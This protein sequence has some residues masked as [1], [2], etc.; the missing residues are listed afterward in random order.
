MNAGGNLLPASLVREGR[1]NRIVATQHGVNSYIY[2][3]SL[4]S[5]GAVTTS[6]EWLYL[7]TY[8][9]SFGSSVKAPTANVVAQFVADYVSEHGGNVSDADIAAAV[10][11]YFEE[12]PMVTEETDPTVP[13]WAKAATKPSYTAAE[14]GALPSTYTPPNQTAEQVGADPKGTAAGAVSAHNTSDDAHS[15]IRLLIKALTDRLNGF[16]DIDDTT[17]DQLSEVLD[18][19]SDNADLIEGITTSKV[20]VSDIINNLTTNVAN[21]PLS[22]A[23][24]VALKKLIDA[25]TVPTKTSQLTNDSGFLTAH[26]D[27]SGKADKSSAETWTFALED[28]SLVTKKVV[29]A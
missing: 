1:Y 16:L 17:A 11:A 10:E 19:I 22:A 8:T 7:S 2:T 21:K 24:G 4:S 15:D 13:A 5:A 25:I 27:I 12:N 3:I 6:S 29:L 9:E 26:Q 18:L 28:G 14:V 23:Q 20:N